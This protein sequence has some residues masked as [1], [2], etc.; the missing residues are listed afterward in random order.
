MGEISLAC[1]VSCPG[2]STGDLSVELNYDRLCIG[3]V[4][5]YGFSARRLSRLSGFVLDEGFQYSSFEEI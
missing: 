2:Y 4:L 5:D 1:S 3:L